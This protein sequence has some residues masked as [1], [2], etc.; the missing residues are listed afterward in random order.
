MCCPLS[1]LDGGRARVRAQKQPVVGDPLLFVLCQFLLLF[2][3]TL[4]FAYSFGSK[5]S[6]FKLIFR[7]D[8]SDRSRAQ[9]ET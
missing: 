2:C 1:V 6:V 4:L 8:E 7:G 5:T 9:V 3:F